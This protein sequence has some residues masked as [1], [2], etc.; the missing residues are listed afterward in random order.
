MKHTWWRQLHLTGEQRDKCCIQ[1]E[2][3]ARQTCSITNGWGK[4]D[5]SLPGKWSY[6]RKEVIYLCGSHLH[7]PTSVTGPPNT[8]ALEM[9]HENPDKKPTIQFQKIARCRALFLGFKRCTALPNSQ[10]TR[11]NG[12]SWKEMKLNMH[13]SPEGRKGMTWRIGTPDSLSFF[14]L[15]FKQEGILLCS[16]W[17]RGQALNTT[18]FLPSIF[19]STHRRWAISQLA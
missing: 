15:V 19:C 7:D 11:G 4:H 2:K 5:S 10:M 12:N 6:K 13:H 1:K 14:F 16:S 8:A 17:S 18:I 9:K 3:E